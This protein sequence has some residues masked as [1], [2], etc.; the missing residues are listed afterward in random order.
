MAILASALYT[1]G[2]RQA[3]PECHRQPAGEG[4]KKLRQAIQYR[5]SQHLYNACTILWGG[6]NG[7]STAVGEWAQAQ[8]RQ[9]PTLVRLTSTARFQPMKMRLGVAPV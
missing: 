8:R 5:Q 7:G 2:G 4:A 6:D 9:Y 3:R 1:R